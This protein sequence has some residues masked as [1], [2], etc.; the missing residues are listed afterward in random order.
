MANVK[1]KRITTSF[2]VVDEFGNIT[3]HMEVSGKVGAPR[4]ASI[5]RRETDNKL[6]TVRNVEYSEDVYEMTEKEFFEHARKVVDN[7]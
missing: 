3:T 5:A 4:A 2:D 6:A 7:G 1:R